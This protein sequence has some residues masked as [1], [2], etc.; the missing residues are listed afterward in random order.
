M[1][2][3]EAAEAQL[4]LECEHFTRYLIGESPGRGVI[5]SY[6]RAHAVQVVDPPGGATGFDR[7]LVRVAARGGVWARAADAHARFFAKGGLLRR[8]LV[9]LLAILETDARGRRAAD[10]VTS[11]SLV[12]LFF[13]LAGRGLG[14]A[15]LLLV[16]L[17]FFWVLRAS[18]G[19]EVSR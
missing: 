11:S 10:T 9:L 19:T 14:F 12:V 6:L 16:G 8:K 18:S 17:P 1:P 4:S 15:A 7:A 3:P 5:G 2:N 13:S